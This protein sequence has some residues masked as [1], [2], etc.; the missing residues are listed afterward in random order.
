MKLL[1]VSID[2]KAN[3]Y[4]DGKVNSRNI[5]LA[6]GHRVTLGFMQAG[7]YTFSTGD[8]ELMTLLGGD[9]KVLLPGESDWRQIEVGEEFTVPANS[10]FDV[11]VQEYADYHCDYIKE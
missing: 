7:E 9:M 1:N 11:F 6:D 5:Y 3:T 2:A 4:F 10:S 8:K